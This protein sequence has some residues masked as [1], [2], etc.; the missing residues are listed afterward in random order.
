MDRGT[1]R[2]TTFIDEADYKA[3]LNTVAEAHRLW[4]IEVF[5]YC[6]MKKPLPS[7]LKNS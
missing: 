2:Q 5:S 6:L 4:G 3:F 1:A 7:V